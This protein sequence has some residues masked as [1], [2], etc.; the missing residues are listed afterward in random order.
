MPGLLA[1]GE[2]AA[3][4]VARTAVLGQPAGHPEV[5][6]AHAAMCADPRTAALIAR[7]PDWTAG[8]KLSGHQDPRFAPNLLNLLA[9]MGMTAADHPRIGQLL[10]Q[11][12]DHQDPDG[13]FMSYGSA[14]TG[15]EPVWGALPCDSHAVAETLVR[16]GFAG[17]SRVQRALARMAGDLATTAQGPAWLCL[18]HTVTGFRG[19]GRK[20]DFCPQVTL[21]ALRAFAMLPP[22]AQPSGLT[23]AARVA[24]RAWRMRGAEKP[25]M[26]GHGK[27]FKTVKWPVTW[28]GA[29]AV[30]DTLG[31]YPGLWREPAADPADRAALAELAACLVAYNA[32][33]AGQVVPRSVTAASSPS[34]SGRRRAP[35]RSP[36]RAC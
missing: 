3:R 1:S 12:L 10:G 7:L 8:D 11:F 14:R 29:Y 15:E 28:Y 23:G 19:P 4:W 6:E 31:R 32:G 17:D 35:R 27:A 36:P 5:A 34:R 13:R 21:Q 33:P 24:L 30:L 25:Y 20:T 22:S 2:P 18:P 16:Y 26:F 9:D